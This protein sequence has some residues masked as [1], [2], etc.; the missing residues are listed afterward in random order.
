MGRYTIARTRELGDAFGVTVAKMNPVNR[1]IPQV[2][3]L[4]RKGTW[5]LARELPLAGPQDLYSSYIG[6]VSRSPQQRLQGQLQVATGPNNE[7]LK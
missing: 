5:P 3:I 4:D 1:A 6:L 2:E 7:T